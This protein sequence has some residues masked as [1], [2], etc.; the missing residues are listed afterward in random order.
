MYVKMSE[1]FIKIDSLQHLEISWQTY[2]TKKNSSVTN[3]NKTV[4]RQKLSL[5]L[6]GLIQAAQAPCFLKLRKNALLLR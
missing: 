4:Q 3:E 6:T 1:T 2:A 5:L